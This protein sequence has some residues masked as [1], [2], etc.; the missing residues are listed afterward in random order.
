MYNRSSKSVRYDLH[1]APVPRVSCPI[2][3]RIVIRNCP[4]LALSVVASAVDCMAYA[5]VLAVVASV[6]AA[7]MHVEDTLRLAVASRTMISTRT[8]LSR[9]RQEQ[10]EGTPRDTRQDI[11]GQGPVATLGMVWEHTR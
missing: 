6:G 1:S 11:W 10:E 2:I 8:I 7:A 5:V 3:F 4:A 9:R